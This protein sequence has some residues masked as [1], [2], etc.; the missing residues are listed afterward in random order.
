MLLNARYSLQ[1]IM[2]VVFSCLYAFFLCASSAN[3]AEQAGNAKQPPNIVYIMSDELA[4]YELS[5]MGNERIRT[6]N[7]DK[8]ASEGIP[9]YAGTCRRARVRATQGM[10][11]DGQAYG[12]LFSAGQSGGD[13]PSCW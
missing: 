4:Y 6:P 3:A 8:M 11:D 5:H 2:S 12:A 1:R 7:M 13:T 9:F 10:H